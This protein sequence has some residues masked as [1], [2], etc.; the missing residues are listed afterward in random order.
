MLALEI[1]HK[2]LLGRVH[3]DAGRYEDAARCYRAVVTKNPAFADAHYALGEA[4]FK[5]GRVDAA[6]QS[7][8]TALALKPNDA[9]A[10]AGIGVAYGW[11]GDGARAESHLNRAI[12]LDPSIA[13]SHYLYGAVMW[14]Y[15]RFDEARSAYERALAVDP[16]Y[17]E[18]RFGRGLVRLVTGDMPGGWEDYEFRASQQKPLDPT[19]APRWRGEDP[20]GRTI[21]LYGE[22]G[23]GDTLLFMRYVP[24]LA[25][26][27]ARVLLSVPI[28]VKALAERLS[29]V[30]AI[31]VEP[32]PE[33]PPFDW[34]CPLG[35]L[36]LTFR[37]TLE[38]IPAEVPYLSA[39]PE[40]IVLWQQRVPASPQFTVAMVWSGNPEHPNNH[41]RMLRFAELAPLL[42]IPGVRYLL[43][44]K[45]AI[46]AQ[47]KGCE[48]QVAPGTSVELLGD[49]LQDFADTAAI[50][51]GVDLVISVDTSLCHLAGA[52][53]RPVWT[54]LSVANDWRWLAGHDDN[55][56]FP[57]MRL[58][59]QAKLGVWSDVVSRVRGD[60]DLLVR[61]RTV[62]RNDPLQDCKI[63]IPQIQ[64]AI[65]EGRDSQSAAE[66]QD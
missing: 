11:T 29:G 63:E 30:S 49:A 43:L 7:F 60:L 4:L 22:Q 25:A 53:G 62:R 9:T 2:F 46:A 40:R 10:H 23:I 61:A 56:W 59:R 38:T 21:L 50:L 37:T 52:L 18:A 44:Q 47:A 1:R 65:I 41:N 12:M 31:L 39:P 34:S 54:L 51:T 19:L 28:G 42:S 64:A 5:C 14:D 26:L 66:G 15:G 13:R 35:S 33:L 20:S 16:T 57:T 32:N 6:I 3:R 36:P 58:Y 17:A 8:R 45:G 27:G 55:P 24:R 48:K